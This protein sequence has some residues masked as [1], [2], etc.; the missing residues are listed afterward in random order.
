MVAKPVAGNTR[1]KNYTKELVLLNLL[2]TKINGTEGKQNANHTKIHILGSGRSA[3]P[4]A[5]RHRAVPAA[6]RS[7]Q[8]G[9]AAQHRNR[10]SRRN[11]ESDGTALAAPH[12]PGIPRCFLSDE[13]T[14]RRLGSVLAQAV[15]TAGFCVNTENGIGLK[16]VA[17]SICGLEQAAPSLPPSEGSARPLQKGNTAPQYGSP[18]R[19]RARSSSVQST[20]TLKIAV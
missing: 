6:P 4:A 13:T 7:T 3:R 12:T 19:P 16:H 5:A 14:S 10:V 20:L 2:S 8:Q 9:H 15:L 11:G 18:E 17:A 1:L